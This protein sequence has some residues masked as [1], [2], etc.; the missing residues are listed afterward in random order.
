MGDVQNIVES[1]VR[2]NAFRAAVLTDEY[3]LPLGA[4]PTGTLSEAPAATVAQIRRLFERVHGRVGLRAMEEVALRDDAGQR[5]VC[6]RIVVGEYD[7][8][9]AVLVPP[10][11]RCRQAIDQAIEAIRQAFTMVEESD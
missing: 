2:E 1:L 8:I 3:G 6:R 11:R 10:G 4:F 5:L 9:L 7:L